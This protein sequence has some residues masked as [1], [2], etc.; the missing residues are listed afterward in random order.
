M[1]TLEIVR[2]WKDEEYRETLTLKQRGQVPEHPSG[3]LE[4]EESD[5]RE[6]DPFKFVPVASF[7][8]KGNSLCTGCH[9]H[10]CRPK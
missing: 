2:A 10:H 6:D 7:F 8:L 1:P 3:V 9:T 4:F 5:Q